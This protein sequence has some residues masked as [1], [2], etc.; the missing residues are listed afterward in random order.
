MLRSLLV[1]HSEKKRS[2]Q[3]RYNWSNMYMKNH[4]LT[5]NTKCMINSHC[6]IFTSLKVTTVL[7]AHY[8][9]TI[10]TAVVL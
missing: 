10:C 9:D 1:A 7:T 6:K 4:F 2:F 5:Q 3:I 8:N